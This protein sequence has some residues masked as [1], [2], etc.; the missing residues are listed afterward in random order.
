MRCAAGF[1]LSA[2]LLAAIPGTTTAAVQFSDSATLSLPPGYVV[3][4]G[5]VF[6][7]IDWQTFQ[8][9]IIVGPVLPSPIS[10]VPTPPKQITESPPP[11]FLNVSKVPIGPVWNQPTLAFSTTTAPTAPTSTA[12]DV[13]AVV[14]GNNQFAY[15]LYGTLNQSNTGNMV[16]SPY[17]IST[18]LAMTY[19]GAAGQT[20]TEMAQTMHFTLPESQLAPAMGQ[21]ISQIN[22]Q[23]GS[24]YQLSVANHLWGQTG[25]SFLPSF[26]N[27]TSSDYQCR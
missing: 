5:P 7:P 11:P 15:D 14:S 6:S 19:A 12:A 27:T 26:L 16:F 21:L 9:P 1:V 22:S 13:A 4:H 8:G 18:A 2:I 3:Y 25:F 17:S 20:A 10:K 24:N 23:G